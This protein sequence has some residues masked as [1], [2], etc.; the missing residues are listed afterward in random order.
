MLCEND[1]YSFIKL[2]FFTVI[3]FLIFSPAGC[4]LCD[5][6]DDSLIRLSVFIIVVF[7][8]VFTGCVQCKCDEMIV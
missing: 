4:V 1:D 2:P 8:I 5:Y 3:V 6:D 7:F